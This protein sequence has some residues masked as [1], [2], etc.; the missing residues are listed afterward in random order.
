M[1]D[2][3]VVL[4]AIGWVVW[5]WLAVARQLRRSAPISPPLFASA[6]LFALGVLLLLGIGASPLHLLWWFPLSV[7]LG[8][9]LLALPVWVKFNMRCLSWL[10]GWIHRGD[11]PNAPS[12]KPSVRTGRGP[13]TVRK[14]PR[15]AR[16]RRSNRHR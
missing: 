7:V 10:T 11:P 15:P 5:V 13:G 6:N 12:I 8:V 16:L 3:L 1:I 4:A 9:L 2:T 14:P